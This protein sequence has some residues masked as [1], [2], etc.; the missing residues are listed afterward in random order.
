MSLDS[1]VLIRFGADRNYFRFDR[2][3]FGAGFFVELVS[4]LPTKA[5]PLAMLAR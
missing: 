1:Q 2:L 3:V 4:L 5:H